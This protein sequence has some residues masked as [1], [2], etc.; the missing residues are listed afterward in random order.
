MIQSLGFSFE[1]NVTFYLLKLCIFNVFFFPFPSWDGTG[2]S[3]YLCNTCGATFHRA[4]ALS[5]HLK[6]HQPK[7]TGRAFACVQWVTPCW[8][9]H[10]FSRYWA[11][12]LRCPPRLSSPFLSFPSPAAVTRDSTKQKICSSIWTSTWVWSLSSVRCVG[13]ATAGRR[14][15][16]RMWSRIA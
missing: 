7:P 5:K 12:W 16:T 15:G 8:I 11:C 2:E 4:S 9:S 13:S 14:T 10:I 3:K 6:K 1:E